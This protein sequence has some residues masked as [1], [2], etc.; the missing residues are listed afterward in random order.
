MLKITFKLLFFLFSKNKMKKSQL[1]QDIV[2]LAVNRFKKKGFF[3]EF[4]ATDGFD[5]SNTYLLEKKYNWTGIVAEPLPAW[6]SN[7]RKNRNCTIDTRCLWS[8]SNQNLEFINKKKKELSTIKIFANSDGH[9]EVRKKSNIIKVKSVSLI[10]L[11]KFH[12]A[13]KII[14]YMSIDTEGSELDILQNFPFDNYKFN[15]IS[16]EHNYGPNREKLKEL[17]NK[18]GYKPFLNNLS[19]WDDWFVPIKKQ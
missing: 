4:G 7:L 10:D 14:D 18:N 16:V 1:G 5:L 8:S 6:H 11:L 9:S 19:K 13:P 12:N 3:I 15:L 17:L 2:A